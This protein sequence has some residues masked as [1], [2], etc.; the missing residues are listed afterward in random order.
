MRVE[1]EPILRLR[2][3]RYTSC[4]VVTMHVFYT[5]IIFYTLIVH[6]LAKI[7]YLWCSNACFDARPGLVHLIRLSS[8]NFLCCT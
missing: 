2:E 1:H 7:E 8:N 4:C 3:E 5:I 6:V